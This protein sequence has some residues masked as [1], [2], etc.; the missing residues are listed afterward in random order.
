MLLSV[1]NVTLSSPQCY[2]LQSHKCNI[3]MRIGLD[4][5]NEQT[6]WRVHLMSVF[7]HE[8]QIRVSSTDGFYIRDAM[9]ILVQID[10]SVWLQNS[11]DKKRNVSPKNDL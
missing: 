4:V 8:S 2:I 3:N 7:I 9:I 5:I 6:V 11:E 1:A 10:Y